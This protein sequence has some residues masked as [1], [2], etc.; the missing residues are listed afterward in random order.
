MG[1]GGVEGINSVYYKLAFE[2]TMDD[3]IYPELIPQTDLDANEHE[4][5]NSLWSEQLC[6]SLEE[7]LRREQLR[8]SSTA[9]SI[10]RRTLPAVKD[11]YKY[12]WL[13]W[14]YPERTE[15][16]LSED[17]IWV[18]SLKSLNDPM[19]AGFR[20]PDDAIEAKA[21]F[22][23][24][25]LMRSQWTGCFC[26]SIDPV[27]ILMW[28][29]YAQGHK[30]FCI[31]Y[32]RQ[33]SYLLSSPY[34][35]PVLYRRSMPKLALDD[36]SR[37]QALVDLV[38]WTK[39]EE[40]E[41]EREWRLRYPRADAYTRVGLVKPYGVIFGLKTEPEDRRFIRNCAPDLHYGEI[42]PT[43]QDYRLRIVW[44]DNDESTD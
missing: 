8:W 40:W 19:E 17:K 5:W 16:I 22:S 18:A 24:V 13:D 27:S 30:G 37:L 9:P 15:S 44:E 25:Y 39:S 4:Y 14:K 31:K 41:Y 10:R 20:G 12:S 35:K 3:P 32:R 23:F 42:N 33:D 34:C 6:A 43:E 26:F 7:N 2:E 1:D 11:L 29:H 28:S 38:F 21:T 36:P